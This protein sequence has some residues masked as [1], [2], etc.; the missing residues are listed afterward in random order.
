MGRSVSAC[1]KLIRGG[2]HYI[3]KPITRET[4]KCVRK[5]YMLMKIELR[6]RFQRKCDNNEDSLTIQ[7]IL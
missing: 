6:I 7:A 3:R 1:K 2:G 5:L 4:I